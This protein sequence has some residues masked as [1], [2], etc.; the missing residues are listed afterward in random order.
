MSQ[1][2][3]QQSQKQQKQLEVSSK[4]SPNLSVKTLK[5]NGKWVIMLGVIVLIIFIYKFPI[6]MIAQLLD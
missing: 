3:P 2:T 1:K 5:R 6:K 4:E